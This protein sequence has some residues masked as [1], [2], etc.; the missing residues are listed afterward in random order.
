MSPPQSGKKPVALP[1]V[2]PL[3][4]CR[5]DGRPYERRPDVEEQICRVRETDPATWPDLAKAPQGSDVRLKSETIVHLV[6]VLRKRGESTIT[7][8]LIEQ[9]ICRA[10]KTTKTWAKGFDQATTEEIIFE[11]GGQLIELILAETPSR[12]SEFL[13]IAF[14]GAVK[15]RTL[16]AVERRESQ[17]QTYHFARSTDAGDGS[18]GTIAN[19]LEG[20]ADDEPGPHEIVIAW[21]R[22]DE[23]RKW[24]G[25]ISNP[26]HREAVVLHYFEEWPI[27]CKDKAKPS[28]CTHFRISARQINNWF[29]KAF[30]E[31]RAAAGDDL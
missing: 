3:T 26:K 17:P 18:D 16:N 27:Q 23:L 4:K 12:Q 25:A 15:R 28:L 11:V 6:R 13:E 22:Q 5:L 7:G 30:E 14:A 24:I 21:E 31:V 2:E 19:P 29:V 9:L 10:G 20:A 1:G 8:Q